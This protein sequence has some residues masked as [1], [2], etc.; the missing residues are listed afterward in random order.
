MNAA[1]G[2]RAKGKGK[3]VKVEPKKKLPEKSE[4][5]FWL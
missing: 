4:T 1:P 5:P 3:R 2:I